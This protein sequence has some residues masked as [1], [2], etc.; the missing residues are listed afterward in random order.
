M[1]EIRFDEHG[2]I[3]AIVQDARTGQVLTLA[4]MNRESLQKTL[5]LGETVFW[6]RSRQQ[7]WHKGETSGNTQR[8]VK[9]MLDCDGDALLVQVIPAGP[10]CHTGAVSCFFEE[11]EGE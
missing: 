2:L 11:L 3:P 4:Y 6:S 9:I 1:R 5:E 8:V 7:F 10:A